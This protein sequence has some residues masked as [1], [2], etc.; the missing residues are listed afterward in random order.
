MEDDAPVMSTAYI[1]LLDMHEVG[2]GQVWR[3]EELVGPKS[4]GFTLLKADPG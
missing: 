2:E 4:I 1:G 3:L